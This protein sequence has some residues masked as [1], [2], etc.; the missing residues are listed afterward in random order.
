[1]D[2]LF[3]SLTIAVMAL[4]TVATKDGPLAQIGM[5]SVPL[6]AI[7]AITV[8]TA[9]AVLVFPGPRER[10][11][12]NLFS[13]MAYDRLVRGQPS[14]ALK[15]YEYVD[16]HSL[17][18]HEDGQLF[19]GLALKAV[20]RTGEMQELLVGYRQLPSVG[21]PLVLPELEELPSAT[22]AINLGLALCARDQQAE[23]KRLFQTIEGWQRNQ[24]RQAQNADQE[25]EARFQA[26]VALLGQGKTRQAGRE[27]KDIKGQVRARRAKGFLKRIRES[28][29]LADLAGC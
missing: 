11:I 10:A 17:F 14:V 28:R 6:V 9:L 13:Q 2:E 26:S 20:G 1:L 15:L 23:A 18:R 5:A 25:L 8:L 4:D 3:L 29:A 19:H 7:S 22:D 21:E 24:A 27:I 16:D 12:A